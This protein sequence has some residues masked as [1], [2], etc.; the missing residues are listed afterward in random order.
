[1]GNWNSCH[2]VWPPARAVDTL[3]E[4]QFT[5]Y[6]FTDIFGFSIYLNAQFT[7][8]TDFQFTWIHNTGTLFYTFSIYLNAQFRFSNYFI[9]RA[10]LDFQFTWMI[11]LLLYRFSIYFI[12]RVLLEF[13]IYQNVQFT[14]YRFS[15]YF[16]LRA[17]LDF[18]LHFT[19]YSIY[20]W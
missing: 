17:L 8:F 3:P 11:S 20:S 2:R 9:L 13:S 1:M 19:E 12:L 16:I 7:R 14:V 5:R 10:L 15:I 4:F 6:Q 18:Q